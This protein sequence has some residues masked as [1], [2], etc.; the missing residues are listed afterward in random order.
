L[1]ELRDYGVDLQRE[2][3]KVGFRRFSDGMIFSALREIISVLITRDPHVS[4]RTRAS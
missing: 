2:L 3:M 4:R 1:S